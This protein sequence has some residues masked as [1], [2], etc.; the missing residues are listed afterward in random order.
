MRVVNKKGEIVKSE[1]FDL[2]EN[3]SIED[4]RLSIQTSEENKVIELL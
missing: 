1:L 4:N 2:I 3:F